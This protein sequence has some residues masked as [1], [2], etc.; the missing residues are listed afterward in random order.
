[1]SEKKSVMLWRVNMASFGLF[2]VLALTGM[3]NWLLLPRGY[4]AGGGDLWV[5]L[6]HFLR[7]VHEWT[8]VLFII[9]VLIHL[10]LHW[11]TIRSKLKKGA[12]SP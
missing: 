1:M 9:A 8:A 5:S 11:G 3:I 10:A 4:G 2:C 6:R 7:F 12:N